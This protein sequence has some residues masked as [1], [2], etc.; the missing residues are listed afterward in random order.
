MKNQQQQS[1]Q[2]TTPQSLLHMLSSPDN[3]VVSVH[4]SA[5]TRIG[6]ERSCLQN[7]E[8]LT[9]LDEVLDIVE[10]GF[11]GFQ[12]TCHV[13]SSTTGTFPNSGSQ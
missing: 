9:I 13:S 5:E 8:I 10:D 12:T 7:E 11:S 3:N 1:N 6:S 2:A 4:S